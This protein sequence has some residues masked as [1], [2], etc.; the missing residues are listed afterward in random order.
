MYRAFGLPPHFH[1]PAF[2]GAWLQGLSGEVPE[3]RSPSC[4]RKTS[5]RIEG[6]SS[7]PKVA[8]RNLS[9]T[10]SGPRCL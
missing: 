1:S 9:G 5:N 2:L 10:R 7:T 3:T 8:A 6:N 4:A